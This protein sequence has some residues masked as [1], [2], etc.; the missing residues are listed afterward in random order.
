MN[1]FN[2]YCYFLICVFA[3]FQVVFFS[4]QANGQDTIVPV[5]SVYI[6]TSDSAG[7]LLQNSNINL[8]HTITTVKGTDTSETKRLHHAP[9]NDNFAN[10]TVL[11]IGAPPTAGTTVGGT[12]QAG[13][14]SDCQAQ[15]SQGWFAQGL[16]VGDVSVVST[17]WY[18][19]TAAATTNYYINM[20]NTGGTYEH[21]VVVW[22]G[23]SS[24]P[25]S[26]CPQP[27]ACMDDM[28]L[29]YISA[30]TSVPT[31]SVEISATAGTVYYIQVCYYSST[32]GGDAFK[33]GVS[34]TA[35]Y[36]LSNPLPLETVADPIATTY[37]TSCNPTVG[38]IETDGA[39][40]TILTSQGYST[41]ATDPCPGGFGYADIENGQT[42]SS[43][44]SFSVPAGGL[45]DYITL[46]GWLNIEEA[47][48][49]GCHH[50]TFIAGE[51]WIEWSMYS[52]AG[53]LL[54]CGG[55][56]TNGTETPWSVSGVA[57]N[58]SYIMC[59]STQFCGYYSCAGSAAYSS[60][61]FNSGAPYEESYWGVSYD[62][63]DPSGCPPPLCNP[64]PIGLS[65]FQVDYEQ[66]SNQVI[67]YWSCASQTNNKLF[68]VQ[69]SVDGYNWQ[70]VATLSGA[71]TTSVELFY[72]ATDENPTAG[73]TY[74]RLMQTDYDGAFTYSNVQ[75]IDIPYSSSASLYPNPT[76][77]NV[78]LRYSTQSRDPIT[79]KI[80]DISGHVLNTYTINLVI[81]GTN[82][83][84][85]LTSGLAPGMYIMEVSNSQKTFHL[86]FVKQ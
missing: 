22:T 6:H 56:G 82:D 33:I 48:G 52:G 2:K 42:F 46:N 83:Y 78:F 86:K 14:V 79:I 47:A 16:L 58:S 63:L 64:L 43:C 20:D 84:E 15:G 74:Y 81:L 49:G 36:F 38:T 25:V 35:S 29:S 32:N 75:P 24:W 76:P 18:T 51:L 73:I 71:G 26:N 12:L 72:N 53:T 59:W 60:D 11:T 85:V 80:L 40:Y 70:T 21:G 5:K 28:S 61:Y 23:L 50:V 45:A 39:P 54:T 13:E 37:I 66:A 3:P 7:I 17:V 68:T 30:N 77:D 31:Y 69:K 10:A 67:I 8:G 4:N 55:G 57:C 27:I 44:L 65:S 9:G 1:I 62:P 34:T 19:F 41:E